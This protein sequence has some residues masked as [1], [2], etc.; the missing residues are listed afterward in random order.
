MLCYTLHANI[1]IKGARSESAEV[2]FDRAEFQPLHVRLSEIEQFLKTSRD[3][4]VPLNENVDNLVSELNKLGK[5]VL[6][7]AQDTEVELKHKKKDFPEIKQDLSH[8]CQECDKR[9]IEIRRLQEELQKRDHQLQ[10]AQEEAQVMQENLS[11]SQAE[12][13]EK[14][15]EV[16]YLQQQR[17]E[18]SITLYAERTESR[19]L[20]LALQV[21]IQVWCMAIYGMLI[22]SLLLG[23]P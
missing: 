3:S 14:Y 21:K 11:K 5:E 23:R 16:Y 9:N 19:K 20:I 12:L 8:K 7:L 13:E 4:Q 17:K 6:K 10:S 15:K 22:T 1:Y 2:H 18:L